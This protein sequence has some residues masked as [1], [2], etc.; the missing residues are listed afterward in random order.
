MKIRIRASKCFRCN[1]FGPKSLDCKKEKS[2]KM[3]K[4]SDKDTKKIE[5]VNSL[6]APKDM[7]KTIVIKGKRFNALVD[8]G[9][10]FNIVN[11]SS[12]Y[13]VGASTLSKST[14][15]F[16]GFGG[17]K[18]IPLGCFKDV[19]RL[20]VSVFRSYFTWWLIMSCQ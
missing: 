5:A 3:K 19:S 2:K 12:H 18:V 14:L 1:E 17:N 8:T 9:S 15:H 6:S 7:Y 13:K 20:T 16:S 4:S 10:Q 11:Q